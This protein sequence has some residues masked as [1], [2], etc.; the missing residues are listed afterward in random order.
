MNTHKMLEEQL[1]K[2][3]REIR[4]EHTPDWAVHKRIA[5]KTN[6]LVVPTIPFVGKNY[7]EQQKKVLVY[8]SAENLTNHCVGK[9]TDR[10]WLDDDNEAENRHRKCFDDKEMQKKQMDP[11][12]PYVHC[13]P[14]ETG[15][16]LTAAMYIVSKLE[17]M[18][19]DDITPREFCERISF[20]NY[21]KYSKETPYQ[22]S[23]RKGISKK[24]AKENIDYAGN[25]ELMKESNDFIKAD[26]DILKP[27]YIILPGSMYHAAKSF[28]DHIKV[29]A[30]IIPIYQMLAGNVH[31]HIAPNERNKK[32][33]KKYSVDD[34]AP[35]VR[36]AYHGMTTVSLEKYLYVFGYL[37]E[38]LDSLKEEL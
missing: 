9:H 24:E 20:G 30:V 8:A 32:N 37:D 26:I 36:T 1:L 10:P 14:M 22:L 35:A 6:E 38:V 17:I 19:L 18:T 34:L 21:G 5:D 15:L 25:A 2:T 23:N 12:I 4:K 27:D 11:V 33:Y 13:G 16:L 3:Y 29:N 7:A 28:I 31:N